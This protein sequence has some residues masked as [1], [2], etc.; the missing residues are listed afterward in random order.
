MCNFLQ[1]NVSNTMPLDVYHFVLP[2]KYSPIVDAFILLASKFG[3]KQIPQYPT[4][5]ISTNLWKNLPN[6]GSVWN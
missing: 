1:I 4:V 5:K 6:S 2:K 3:L